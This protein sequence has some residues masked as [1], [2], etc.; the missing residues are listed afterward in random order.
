MENSNQQDL[1]VSSDIQFSLKS[2]SGWAKFLSILGFISVLF[3]IAF[4]ISFGPI[5]KRVSPDSPVSHMPTLMFTV[6]YI[7]FGVIYFFPF[8][9][10]IRFA[11]KV[12]QALKNNEQQALNEGFRSLQSHYTFIGILVAILV[13]IYLLVGLGV[14]ISFMIR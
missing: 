5:M 8:Y 13:G 10:L 9:F 12:K 14:G 6:I 7:V 3:L 11:V 1:H 2:I 4:G